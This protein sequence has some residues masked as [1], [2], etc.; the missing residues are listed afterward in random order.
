MKSES[1]FFLFIS[2]ISAYVYNFLPN[3]IK[4]FKFLAFGQDKRTSPLTFLE[5]FKYHMTFF[6]SNFRLS[7]PI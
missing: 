3:H 6:F 5:T 4:A 7:P 1:Y 2:E